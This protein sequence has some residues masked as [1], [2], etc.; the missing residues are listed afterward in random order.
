MDH[1]KCDP[2]KRYCDSSLKTSLSHEG[3]G[4]FMPVKHVL[5]K[6]VCPGEGSR[7]LISASWRRLPL[8][9]PGPCSVRLPGMLCRT[10]STGPAASKPMSKTLTYF[11]NHLRCYHLRGVLLTP[12]PLLKRILES[13]T[14]GFP[15][16]L[17]SVF[18][19]KTITSQVC[20][21]FLW[22]YILL[23]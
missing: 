16:L 17:D 22:I 14:V 1:L 9:A 4:N 23:T 21:G 20:H 13:A 5:C 8:P 15:E 6:V 3:V 19:R 18:Q 12:A 2:K 11:P 10:L 7:R